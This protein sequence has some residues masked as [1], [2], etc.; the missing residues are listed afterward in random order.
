MRIILLVSC[1][2]AAE[3]CVGCAGVSTSSNA[4][5]G[6]AHYPPSN[7]ASVRILGQEPGGAGAER[8]GQVYIDVEGHPPREQLEQR[9]RVEAAKLG[10]NAVYIVSDRLH[11]F[12]EVF[13]DFWWGPTETF[14]ETRRDIV[15]VAVRLNA[16]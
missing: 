14:Q 4:F 16:S 2:V 1:L 11:V 12:P 8:L 9:L 13:S 7:P 3:L 15:A 5:L 10:A 6:S